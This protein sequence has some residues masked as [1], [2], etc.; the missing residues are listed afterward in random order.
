MNDIIGSESKV[1]SREYYE[2]FDS[3][4]ITRFIGKVSSIR[5][6]CT[7]QKFSTRCV[8]DDIR[9]RVLSP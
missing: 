7:S 4:D 2:S 1:T 5:V 6:V 8:L 3:D 9:Q